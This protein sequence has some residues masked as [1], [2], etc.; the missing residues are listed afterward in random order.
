MAAILWHNHRRALD[1]GQPLQSFRGFIA[2]LLGQHGFTSIN[3]GS[4][5][6]SAAKG[7]T[8]TSIAHLDLGGN[9]YFEM[10]MT[11]GESVDPVRAANQE[12]VQ[13]L[14]GIANL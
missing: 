14:A 3:A 8:F 11:G 6:V 13:I 4:Q 7:D 12:V 1:P 5:D 9:Q 2:N 10:V